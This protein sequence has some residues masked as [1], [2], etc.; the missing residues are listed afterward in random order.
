[1]EQD[2]VLEAL[3]ERVRIGLLRI[4]WTIIVG[5]LLA[6]RMQ[7]ASVTVNRREITLTVITIAILTLVLSLS[8]VRRLGP[9]AEIINTTADILFISVV[10]YYSGGLASPFYPLYYITLITAAVVL[11]TKGAMMTAFAIG[12]ISPAIH[13]ALKHW[14]VSEPLLV[15]DVVRT[16]PYLFLIAF[17]AGALRDRIRALDETASR[18]RA[19]RAATDREMEVARRVQQAQ[20]P[21]EIPEIEGIEIAILYHPAREV[22]GDLYE[23][24]PVDKARIGIA[25][26]D[27]AG[28]GVPAALLVASAKYG[29]YE[30]FSENLDQ[31]AAEI[32]HHLMSVTMSETF[33]TLAYGILTPRIGEF[34]YINAGHMPPIVVKNNGAVNL[35]MNS[36]IPL[37]VMESAEYSEHDI[38][39]EPGDVLVLYSDGVTDALGNVD[40]L[41]LLQAFLQEVQGSHI[42][43]W[44][45]RLMERIGK[46]HHVDDVTLVA[47]R[48]QPGSI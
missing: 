29:L 24:Y 42:S 46:P 20:L 26:A 4:R 37:G 18:L 33:V 2:R 34:R 19:E 15:D 38:S 5:V 9:I 28:K 12:I 44:G 1:L 14:F 43:T 36:D 21:Q 23:F 6:S 35:Y 16:F 8:A 31:M 13:I 48:I 17:M 3:P 7:F 32:N 10:V 47:V 11:G 30:H 40:G 41:D 45:S 39:L 27:V 25:V 22:G